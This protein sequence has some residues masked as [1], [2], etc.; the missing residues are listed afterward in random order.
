MRQPDIEIYLKDAEHAAVAAWLEQALGPCGPWQERG[1]TLKC[2]ARGEHGAVRV[3]WLPKAV[4][5]WHSLFLESDSTPWDDDLACARAAHAALGVEIRCA[6]GG[7]EENQ[8]EEDADR[9]LRVDAG[10]VEEIT[11]RTA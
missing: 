6:P 1:Q 9:W 8:G 10:G 7:W 3:T 4:G 5:K 11:W 2:T